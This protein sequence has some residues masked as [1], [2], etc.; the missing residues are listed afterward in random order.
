MRDALGTPLPLGS[1]APGLPDLAPA[2][3]TATETAAAVEMPGHSVVPAQNA[4]EHSW[5]VPVPATADE[6]P[7]PAAADGDLAGPGARAGLGGYRYVLAVAG[8]ALAVVAAVTMTRLGAAR[9]TAAPHAR[10]TSVSPRVTRSA[11]PVTRLEETA[12]Q[13][14]HLTAQPGP[15]DIVLTW[16]LPAGARSDGAGIIIRESPPISGD[17]TVALSRQGG[18]PL[19]YIAAP[20]TAGQ[21]VCFTVGVLVER[22]DGTVQLIQA[23]PVCAAPR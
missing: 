6:R 15:G 9:P 3:P 19:T 21:Q 5:Q 2:A 10:A 12:Y 11:P 16:V 20:A 8:V 4:P 13:P 7:G 14:Q 18:L 22:S 17:G 23:G 1:A